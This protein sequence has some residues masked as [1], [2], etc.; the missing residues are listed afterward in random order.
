MYLCH[1]VLKFLRPVSRNK[2]SSLV[3]L[4]PLTLRI[5]KIPKGVSRDDLYILL[6]EAANTTI[7][8]QEDNIAHLSL[9]PAPST[10]D[11]RSY[12]VA[13][14]CFKKITLRFQSFTPNLNLDTKPVFFELMGKRLEVDVD[15]HFFGLT[16]L[17]KLDDPQTE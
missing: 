4:I 3:P 12:Q 2:Q 9:A 6:D 11:S 8:L 7:P 17:N 13:T 14:V 10:L 5:S 16:P 15:D 1:P